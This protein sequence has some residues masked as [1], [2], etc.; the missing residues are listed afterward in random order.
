M[1]LKRH[2]STSRL[3]A[4]GQKQRL[5]DSKTNH[6]ELSNVV[7]VLDI[8]LDVDWERRAEHWVDEEVTGEV[9]VW[10]GM[11][12]AGRS[13]GRCH[14]SWPRTDYLRSSG[15]WSPTPDFPTLLP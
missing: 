5:K 13:A 1:L 9:G 2:V 11:L 3:R 4:R 8:L 15:G 6:D 14:G 12:A 10:L 7:L